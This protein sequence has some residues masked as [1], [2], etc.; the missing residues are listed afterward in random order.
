MPLVL[1]LC[2]VTW[3]QGPMFPLFNTHMEVLIC[4]NRISTRKWVFFVIYC[5]GKYTHTHAHKIKALRLTEMVKS[6]THTHT[7]TQKIKK[8]T[9]VLQRVA[10]TGYFMETLYLCQV[11]NKLASRSV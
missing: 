6:V 11:P 10:H 8:S 2:C 1:M 9:S 5:A 4:F 3:P 7:V